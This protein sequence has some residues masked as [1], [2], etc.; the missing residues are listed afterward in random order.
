[1]SR[2]ERADSSQ[3]RRGP[4]DA[5][6]G[7]K[8]SDSIL[9]DTTNTTTTLHVYKATRMDTGSCASLA[10][11]VVVLFEITIS[12]TA[13][14]STEH[15]PWII[16]DPVRD[17][18]TSVESAHVNPD[19]IRSTGQA[20]VLLIASPLF[21]KAA[22]RNQDSACLLPVTCVSSGLKDYRRAPK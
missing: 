13:E 16:L 5:V 1:M 14:G 21:A 2:A 6:S 17:P 22:T 7:F 3:V 8:W 19:G 20:S 4:T 15:V 10:V 9:I 12:K 18:V 11:E